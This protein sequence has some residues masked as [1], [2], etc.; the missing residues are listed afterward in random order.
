MDL[1][2][3]TILMFGGEN[4]RLYRESQL[5][6]III[7]EENP[8]NH[9]IFSLDTDLGSSLLQLIDASEPPLEIKKWTITFC[10]N[11]PPI[12]SMWKMFFNGASYKE[13]VG[14]GVVLVSPGPKTISLSYKL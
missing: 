3:G 4:K 2:C 11:S 6:Y 14:A 5:T 9:S 12:T 7:D 13:G 8:M 10:E 1:T